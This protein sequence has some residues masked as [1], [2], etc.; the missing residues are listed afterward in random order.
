MFLALTPF[1]PL[2]VFLTYPEAKE[3]TMK[4]DLRLLTLLLPF[5]MMAG[6]TADADDSTKSVIWSL[7]VTS[8]ATTLEKAK[9]IH[10][11]TLLDL[12]DQQSQLKVA[13]EDVFILSLIH[14]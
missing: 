9:E 1:S 13:A 10:D 14:I 12:R 4:F 7:T 6:Q 2:K 8:K 3:M 5:A 11:A